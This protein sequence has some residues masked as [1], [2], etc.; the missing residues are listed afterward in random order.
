MDLSGPGLTYAFLIIPSLFALAVVVQGFVKM[1]QNKPDGTVVLGFG[2]A[3]C[4][5]IAAAYFFFIR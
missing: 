1:S 2:V 4:V 3:F 5:L